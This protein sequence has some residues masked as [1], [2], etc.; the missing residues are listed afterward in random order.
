MG[1]LKFDVAKLERLN[2]PGRFDSLP[3]GVM[4]AALGDPKPRAIVEIGAGTGLFSAAFAHMA[5]DAVVY[6]A[7]IEPVMIEW[8]RENRPE[9]IS[10]SVVPVL[11]QETR[12]PLP[13]GVADVVVMINLH[14]ELAD[15]GSTYAEAH[16]LL[17]PGG[18]LLVVDWKHAETPKGPP[19]EVRATTEQLISALESAGFADITAH[20]ALEWHELLTAAKR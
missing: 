17:D 2:D 4:W 1:Y 14:H 16:R 10:G 18:L 19:L 5:P 15:P 8:M 3:P 13:D 6:A 11:S 7:D 9:V 12:V 20:D